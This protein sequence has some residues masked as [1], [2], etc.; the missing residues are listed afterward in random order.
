MPSFIRLGTRNPAIGFIIPD[1]PNACWPWA[2]YRTRKGY[3][4]MRVGRL[5][6]RAHHLVWSCLYGPPPA[7]DSGLCL[8]HLCFNRACVN[9]NHLEIVTT[10]E[11]SRRRAPRAPSPI[12]HGTPS[13]Y[14]HRRCRCDLCRKAWRTCQRDYLAR[15][16][17]LHG[18][19]RNYDLGCRC[20]TCHQAQLAYRRNLYARKH[21][22]A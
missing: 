22:P 4:R 8:D 21:H 2:G 17:H 1:D 11:N 9:P 5:K 7:R 12:R 16:A 13:A 15:R 20:P 18:T 19:K 14:T 3:G 6:I 10:A